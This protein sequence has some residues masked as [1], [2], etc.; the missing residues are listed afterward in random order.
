M[1]KRS[2]ALIIMQ[3]SKAIHSCLTFFFNK[4]RNY[5]RRNQKN[6]DDTSGLLL[7]L[8]FNF[9]SRAVKVLL[10][11]FTCKVIDI[12]MV[13]SCIF[14]FRHLNFLRKQKKKIIFAF[15]L[16]VYLSLLATGHDKE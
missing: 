16:N 9:S 11:T 3:K 1:S 2:N 5:K 14:F 12:D 6:I 4:R 7:F 15:R 8:K 13:T 10:V